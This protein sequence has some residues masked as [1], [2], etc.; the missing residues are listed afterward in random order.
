[1]K[2]KTF[3]AGA[4]AERSA[5]LAKLRRERPLTGSLFLEKLLKWGQG[6]AARASSRPGGIGRT[7]KALLVGLLA[8]ALPI[9]ASDPQWITLAWDLPADLDASTVT[10]IYTSDTLATPPASWSVLT[11]VAWPQST[12]S[13]MVL[14]ARHYY[15]AT[16]SNFWGESDFS[17][18]ASTPAEPRGGSLWIRRGKP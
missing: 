9:V 3:N 5:W 16:C 15:V 7:K 13:F 8:L 18:V 11:N 12:V 4:S 10:K 6:R 14:P 1:M 2:T 17:N